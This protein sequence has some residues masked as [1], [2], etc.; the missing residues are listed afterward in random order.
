V[1]SGFVVSA[2]HF[3]VGIYLDANLL[4]VL[5]DE[6]FKIGALF[7]PA[8]NC[9]AFRLCLGAYSTAAGTSELLTVYSSCSLSFGWAAM[10]NARLVLTAAIVSR[11][12]VFILLL[13]DHWIPKSLRN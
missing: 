13:F 8:N 3:A 10:P 5:P 6:G 2:Q 11:F 9:S 7:F 1:L 4:A 12:V